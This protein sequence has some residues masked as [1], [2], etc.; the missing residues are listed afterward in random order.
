[1]RFPDINDPANN[2]E[3]L[4]R[5]NLLIEQQHHTTSE[6]PTRENTEALLRKINKMRDLD[7]YQLEEVILPE[8]R[9]E[10]CE[11]YTS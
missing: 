1:M 6:R 9:P 4:N 7:E 2:T 3:S 10:D 11:D 5:M 8:T